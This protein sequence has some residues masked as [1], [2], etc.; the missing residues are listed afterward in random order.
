MASS[1]FYLERRRDTDGSIREE[2]MPIYLYFSFNGKRFQF[3]TGERIDAANWD[4]KRQR[5]RSSCTGSLELNQYLELLNEKAFRIYRECRLQ[6]F[7]PTIEY[8]KHQFNDTPKAQSRNFYDH[9]NSFIESKKQYATHASIKKYRT[10][11]THLKTFS[12]VK[13]YTLEFD[14]I[15]S[16]FYHK[17]IDYFIVDCGHTNN[18]I[19]RTLKTFKTFLNWATKEGYNQKLEFKNF[20]FKGYEGE[21]IHLTF[22]ELMHL[23]HLEIS[24]STLDRVR[25]AFCFGCFSGLRYSDIKNLK[26]ENIQHGYIRSYSIKTKDQLNVPIN[27]LMFEILEKYKDNPSQY[28]IPVM[29]NQKMN[30]YLKDLGKLAEFFTPINIVRF[31]GSERLE[32]VYLKYELLTTHVARKS[33]VTI[34]YQKGV[35]AETIMKITNHKKHDTLKRY[36]KIGDDLKKQAMNN[37]FK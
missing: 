25:D 5:A 9:F 26:K 6:N 14:S 1:R 13:R 36:L 30:E 10:I 16:E 2:S 7:I 15:N 17:F 3:Y 23:Y 19:N 11:L 24:N 32:Q 18:T 27:D 37:I 34:A 20:T 31:R 28:C 21:I 22:E 12:R 4:A 29:S 35:P 33:F 8:F